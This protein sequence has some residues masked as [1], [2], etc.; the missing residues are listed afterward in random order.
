MKKERDEKK[1]RETRLLKRQQLKTLSQSLVARREMGEYMGNEDD[2][3]NGLLRF[4]YA[5]KGYTNLKTFKEWKKE[6]FTVRKGEKALLIWG[7]PVASKAERERIEEL[8]KTR[9]GRGCER[10]LFFRCAT[11]LRKVRCISWRNRLITI[12]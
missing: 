6:G 10:G 12:I 11:S 1:E 5:C 2:T 7:M 4:Y 3:V 8:K 9:S